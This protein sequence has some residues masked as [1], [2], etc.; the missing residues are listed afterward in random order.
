MLLGGCCGLS[1]PQARLRADAG[2][3]EGAT[4]LYEVSLQFWERLDR[5]GHENEIRFL[6]TIGKFGPI[7]PDVETYAQLIKTEQDGYAKWVQ[8]FPYIR[9]RMSEKSDT[10]F[11]YSSRSSDGIL[12]VRDGRIKERIVLNGVG[13]W[14]PQKLD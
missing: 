10:I 4:E 3:P 7:G 1:D 5:I 6:E 9:E 8:I 12:M 13:A 11:Y 14:T 2:F